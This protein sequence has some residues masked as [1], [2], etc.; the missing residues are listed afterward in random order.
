MRPPFPID[1]I[2]HIHDLSNKRIDENCRGSIERVKTKVKYDNA[3]GKDLGSHK[4]N[5]IESR[6]HGKTVFRHFFNNIHG[7]IGSNC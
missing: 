6:Q 2:D 7:R 5:H 1:L 3:R 4:I